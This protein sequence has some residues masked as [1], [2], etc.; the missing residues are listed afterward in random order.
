VLR[1]AAWSLISDGTKIVYQV[2]QV[3]AA[4]NKSESSLWLMAIDRS[5]A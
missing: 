4:K 2:A 5:G 1:T 3:N